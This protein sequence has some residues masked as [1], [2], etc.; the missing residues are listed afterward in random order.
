MD[1]NST[2]RDDGQSSSPRCSLVTTAP[3]PPRDNLTGLTYRVT[4]PITLKSCYPHSLCSS[5]TEILCAITEQID[6]PLSPA[7]IDLVFS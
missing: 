5:S 6:L 3:P 4:V 1:V 2:T 7:E